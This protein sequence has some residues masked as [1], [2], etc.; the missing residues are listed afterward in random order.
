MFMSFVTSFFKDVTKEMFSMGSGLTALCVCAGIGLVLFGVGKM[1]TG[2]ADV[3][4]AAKK[5]GINGEE[6]EEEV[7]GD[8]FE[9]S[10]KTE[11]TEIVQTEFVQTEEE[12]SLSKETVCEQQDDEEESGESQSDEVEETPEVLLIEQTK[13]DQV[14]VSEV[15]DEQTSVFRQLQKDTEIERWEV[16]RWLIPYNDNELITAARLLLRDVQ[17]ETNSLLEKRTA[18]LFEELVATSWKEFD[19]PNDLLKEGGA[20]LAR[21]FLQARDRLNKIKDR[22]SYSFTEEILHESEKFLKTLE[23]ETNESLQ[24]E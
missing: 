21:C 10:E 16:E 17:K 22:I 2:T 19:D 4:K 14:E 6:E 7:Q 8:V 1:L 5:R 12:Q 20:P 11:Q 15:K 18:A 9:E 3:I 23:Q 13:V 24:T